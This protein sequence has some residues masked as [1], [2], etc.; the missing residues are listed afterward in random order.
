MS[1]CMVNLP[2]FLIQP[3]PS[4]PNQVHHGFCCYFGF[5]FYSPI[6]ADSSRRRER[7]K[8]EGREEERKGISGGGAA[9][10]APGANL[11][12]LV[13]RE[14]YGHK[15]KVRPLTPPQYPPKREAIAVS[16]G[17]PKTQSLARRKR[18]QVPT[19]CIFRFQFVGRG[20]K[21]Q[22]HR[23]NEEQR[24]EICNPCPVWFLVFFF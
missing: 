3:S 6:K 22:Y 14:Y 13:S 17:A 16:S 9:V 23:Q 8:M 7:E 18:I 2:N 20:P 1:H 15:K 21:A 4:S 5:S 19:F 11:K 10:S 24:Y 12:D